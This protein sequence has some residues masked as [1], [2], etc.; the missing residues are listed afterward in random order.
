MYTLLC[1]GFHQARFEQSV[2]PIEPAIAQGQG[3]GIR[4]QLATNDLIAVDFARMLV[5]VYQEQQLG[6][7]MPKR[8][9]SRLERGCQTKQHLVGIQLLHQLSDNNA[10]TEQTEEGAACCPGRFCL[11]LLWTHLR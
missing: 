7:W 10:C 4:S 2:D 5:I 6:A 9:I 8:H 11:H 3:R 1:G